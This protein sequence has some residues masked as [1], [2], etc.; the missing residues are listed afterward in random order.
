MLWDTIS[1]LPNDIL[2]KVDRASMAMSLEVRVPF[3]DHTLF[4]F[5][6][7]QPLAFRVQKNQGKILLKELLYRYV[8][9]NLLDRPK[10]GF[11]IPIHAWLRGPLK[12]WAADLITESTQQTFFNTKQLQQAFNDHLNARANHGHLLWNFLMF[13]SWVNYN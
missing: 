13:Q 2:A 11:G 10:A 1:Y 12:E 6:W 4:E 8:P 9:K 3:L 7:T 5:L